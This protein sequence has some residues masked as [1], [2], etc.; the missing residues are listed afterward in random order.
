MDKLWVETLA[1][2]ELIQGRTQSERSQAVDAI[3]EVAGVAPEYLSRARTAYD[4]TMELEEY[5][6]GDYL[7]HV[8]ID[9]NSIVMVWPVDQLSVE[10]AGSYTD[11]DLKEIAI[12]HVERFA[13]S[14]HLGELMLTVGSKGDAVFFRWEDEHNRLFD[15]TAAFLQVGVSRAG[16]L[17]NFENRLPGEKTASTG[18]RG[19][20]AELWPIAPA[21]ALG[22]NEYYAN[23][24]SYWAWEIHNQSHSTQNNAGYCYIAGWCSPKNFYYATSPSGNNTYQ[25]TNHRGRWSATSYMR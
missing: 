19:V 18:F 14:V 12:Q 13:P 23:G 21:Y 25:G 22:A 1:K 10:L 9:T 4:P 6:A 5:R 16:T 8:D 11:E 7:Y 2:I 17:L 24:G 3:R 20:L 15:G